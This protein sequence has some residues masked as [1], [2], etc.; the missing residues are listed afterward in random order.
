MERDIVQGN[1]AK[2]MIRFTVPL[3]LSGMLQQLFNWVDAF[4]VGNAEGELALAGIGATTALY[5]LFVMVITGFTG[6]L[7]VLAARAYGMGEREELNR[8]LSTF[9]VL[10]GGIFTA[11][12][13]LGVLL[14]PS[15]LL[16][17][18][19]PEDIFPIS[20]GYLR[21]IF[22]GI[23]FL[24][25]YNT[26]SAVLRGM[27]NS[28]A[29]F[30]SVLV[31]SGVN[32]ALDV[33]FVVVLRYGAAGAAAATA[34]SQGAMTLFLI[35][36]TVRSY[37]TLRFCPGRGCVRRSSAAGGTGFGLP[38]AIQAGTNSVGN[39][40]LQRFM[41]SFGEQTVAAITT[42]Y[43][44][45]T[46][47]LLP[48][49]NFGSGIAT[50]VAQNIGAGKPERARKALRTGALM[51]AGISL[52]LTALILFA[53]EFLIAIFGLTPESVAIGGDFFRTIASFYVVYSLAMAVRGY[54][55]GTGDMFFSGAAGIAALAVRI[56]CSYA[57]AGLF[58]RKVI[59]YAE[60]FSWVVLLGICLLRYAWKRRRDVSK[61]AG[62]SQK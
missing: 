30:L 9:V 55:E 2:A 14:T 7:S 61:I 13:A 39:I 59:A 31:C 37:P 4:I 15:I 26:Y 22:A 8:I 62:S 33:L 6:G 53:G 27:G 18:D 34:L 46:V 45:D 52:L 20:A 32:V 49:I 41:N 5:N 43:R 36:Y 50:V 38:P 11:V 23:P 47:L 57:F 54:L 17:M 51:M 28:R 35:L 16:A 42:A 1:I 3:I 10:L 58:R 24:A 40:F 48:V 25:V 44:V 19:T 60:A 12:A 29:P 21:I 56:A